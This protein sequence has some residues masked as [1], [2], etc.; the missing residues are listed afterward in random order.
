MDGDQHASRCEVLNAKCLHVAKSLLGFMVL[1][2]C[3]PTV[4]FQKNAHSPDCKL[5]RC[6]SSSTQSLDG[7]GRDDSQADACRPLP[8]QE[9]TTTN[10]Q[11]SRASRPDRRCHP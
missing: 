4:E 6:L 5:N 9:K 11:K 3:R 8:A 2:V 1:V 7:F 10:S